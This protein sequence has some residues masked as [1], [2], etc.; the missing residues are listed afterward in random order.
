MLT[1]ISSMMRWRDCRLK[2][3]VI[4][5]DR[6][7]ELKPEVK[8]PQTLFEEA[9]ERRAV[10][11][12]LDV[13]NVEEETITEMKAAGVV[14]LREQVEERIGI[15]MAQMPKY[16]INPGRDPEGR[17][18][19]KGTPPG[20]SAD[21]P[22]WPVPEPLPEDQLIGDNRQ[23]SRRKGVCGNVLCAT[24][25]KK[26]MRGIWY[27][28]PANPQVDI[29]QYY[30]WLRL[31]RF[32]DIE[33]CADRLGTP[34]LEPEGW[35][36]F[37]VNAPDGWKLAEEESKDDAFVRLWHGCKNYGVPNILRYGLGCSF[38]KAL[39]HRFF[40]GT[41]G[42]YAHGDEYAVKCENYLTYNSFLDDGVFWGAKLELRGDRIG[43][44]PKKDTDQVI[45][46]EG[47]VRIVALWVQGL[48]LQTI[49]SDL[50]SYT[51]Y[52]PTWE[53][54]NEPPPSAGASTDFADDVQEFIQEPEEESAPK[55]KTGFVNT[56]VGSGRF[57]PCAKN[58]LEDYVGQPLPVDKDLYLI[59]L[60][61]PPDLSLPWYT[62]PAYRG[63]EA[64]P[65]LTA[66]SKLGPV[67]RLAY[68]PE[69]QG[70]KGVGMLSAA[71]DNPIIESWQEKDA[72]GAGKQVWVN[73]WT[74]HNKRGKRSGVLYAEPLWEDLPKHTVSGS[75]VVV[76]PELDSAFPS[77]TPATSPDA[78]KPL[79]TCEYGL[80]Q[81]HQLLKLL[82]KKT[83]YLGNVPPGERK[84][85][86]H[87]YQLMKKNSK[88]YKIMK[89]YQLI[90][91]H[92][93]HQ[94]KKPSPPA[95]PMFRI[96]AKRKA[97]PSLAAAAPPPPLADDPPGYDH[98]ASFSDAAEIENSVEQYLGPRP[99]PTSQ[100]RQNSVDVLTQTE[101]Q[102]ADPRFQKPPEG[103][104]DAADSLLGATPKASLVFSAK[105]RALPMPNPAP[106]AAGAP[107]PD[108]IG[109]NRELDRR[110][111]KDLCSIESSTSA[112]SSSSSST[113]TASSLIT[114]ST[115][116][117][118]IMPPAPPA[119]PP[120]APSSSTSSSSSSTRT[121]HAPDGTIIDRTPDG[122]FSRSRLPALAEA[123]P[124]PPLPSC[125]AL[126]AWPRHG[127]AVLPCWTAPLQVPVLGG[128]GWIHGWRCPDT[129][130][131]V[132]FRKRKRHDLKQILAQIEVEIDLRPYSRY[133]KRCIQEIG[134][135]AFKR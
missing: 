6:G 33:T 106:P 26:N 42:I 118:T 51:D 69:S 61:G 57:K 84:V 50:W 115:T 41:P 79:R 110:D 135:D 113:G 54:K 105:R 98:N 87:M 76:V 68:C 127:H 20:Y 103:W 95:A 7:E 101:P 124:A 102:S 11:E 44:I 60:G 116:G 117:G 82:R 59:Q 3:S 78:R 12:A 81:Q 58:P 93:Q 88:L 75:E 129:P 90:K 9:R 15:H 128:P 119:P 63:K 66:G 37:P 21:I 29:N 5:D 99:Q 73:V 36:R 97:L 131:E 52:E 133:R 25:S 40:P 112:T 45:Q 64:N 23:W 72:K 120:A 134:K 111:V 125:S 53:S 108:V 100:L 83:L 13:I 34:S 4:S 39:G 10:V 31:R 49:R 47:T 14:K 104:A 114:R 123:V 121:V 89:Q 85:T 48:N 30:Q 46:K 71:I 92:H 70:R 109:V 43:R 16:V 24:F 86:L 18:I 62:A 28:T 35:W 130:L 1:Q 56:V 55:V 107:P 65:G 122:R 67:R 80:M 22:Q 77:P 94:A 132:S 27:D 74:T 32:D 38:D 2:C 126:P 8:G 19:E 91:Q 17:F 96:V